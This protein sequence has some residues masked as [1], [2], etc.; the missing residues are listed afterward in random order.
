MN[1]LEKYF[2]KEDAKEEKSAFNDQSDLLAKLN[3]DQNST[4]E[5]I[6]AQM[7]KITK[8]IFEATKRVVTLFNPILIE[9]KNL[10]GYDASLDTEEGTKKALLELHDYEVKYLKRDKA[11]CINSGKND[12]IYWEV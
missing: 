10:R 11:I 2:N 5:Q 12:T 4:I 7:A 3:N 6:E 8:T 9:K 1:F